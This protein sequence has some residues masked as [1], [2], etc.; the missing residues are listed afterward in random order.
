MLVK[1]LG[2]KKISYTSKK[3]GEPVVGTTVYY[4]RE[5]SPNDNNLEGNVCGEVYVSANLCAGANI[6]I[7]GTYIGSYDIGQSGKAYLCSFT[8]HNEK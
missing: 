2:K 3:T 6:V 5:D 8:P 1:V 4:V 7:G